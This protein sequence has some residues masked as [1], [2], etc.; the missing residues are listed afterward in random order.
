[1][2]LL[3]LVAIGVGGFLGAITRYFISKRVA[4]GTLVVNLTGSFLIGCVFGWELPRIWTLFFA[5]GLAGALTTFSTLNKELIE[6]WQEGN[7]R[8]AILHVVFTYCGGLLLAWL[9]YFVSSS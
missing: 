6:R 8:E 2:T 4:A 3:H 7:K 5:A 1:M 9:G